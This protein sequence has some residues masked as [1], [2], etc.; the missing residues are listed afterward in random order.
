M[1]SG[2]QHV[3]F[4]KAYGLPSVITST[5]GMATTGIGISHSDIGGYTTILHMKRNIDLMMRWTEMN[6][7]SPLFRCHEGNKPDINIQLITQM[8]QI[9]LRSLKN[10]TH[11]YC[12]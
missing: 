2:D 7:F 4:S 6:V 5:L 1:W 3:D 8:T 10:E 9:C 11:S 12:L